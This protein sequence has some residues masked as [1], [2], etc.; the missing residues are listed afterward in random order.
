M[1][2]FEAQVNGL[3]D[4]GISA[5]STDP[6]DDEL[7]QFLKDGVI[8]VTNIIITLVPALARDFM[9]ATAAQTSNGADL[10]GAKVI[11]VIREDGATNNSW[12][13]CRAISPEEQYLV[14]DDESLYFA[15]AYNPTWMQD[16]DGKI[17]V[18]PTPGSAPNSFKIYYVNN[19]PQN[20]SGVAL[21]HSHSDLKYFPADKVYL[22]TI[23]AAI[24]SIGK[25]MASMHDE[26]PAYS[27]VA[28][29]TSSSTGWTH[30]EHLIKTAEDIELAQVETQALTAEMQ[31]LNAEY[32]WYGSKMQTLKGQYDQAFG[33]MAPKE[34]P[35]QARQAQRA[36]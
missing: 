18:F 36:R 11:S 21:L 10:N 6:T 26:L 2:D 16:E 3:T 8:D 23:Y 7:D 32:Q 33:L 17:S 20:S 22:V 29:G 28:A 1:A 30:I 19:T 15:S 25:K 12:R 4:L 13:A 5:S 35:Q 9:V 24:Q 31:S 14:T 34:Q 27:T